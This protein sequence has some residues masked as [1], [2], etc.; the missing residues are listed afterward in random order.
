MDKQETY[1]VVL[2]ALILGLTITRILEFV[3]NIFY[4][5]N[6]RKQLKRFRVNVFWLIWLF[7]LV[8]QSWWAMYTDWDYS[9]INSLGYLFFLLLTPVILFLI[10]VLLCPKIE[11]GGAP[12]DFDQHIERTRSP[13]FV[14]LGILFLALIPE[15][16]LMSR[17]P[18]SWFDDANITRFFVA[19]LFF[20]APLFIHK[21]DYLEWLMPVIALAILVIFTLFIGDIHDTPSCGLSGEPAGTHIRYPA[22]AN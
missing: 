11:K 8:V 14:L 18:V 21:R 9:T 6:R 7:A 16:V 4:L 15:A 1:I 12:F 10:S 19:V 2:I 20:S 5:E 13:F 3:G 17:C 22:L